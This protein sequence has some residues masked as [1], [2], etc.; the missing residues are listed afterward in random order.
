MSN[1]AYSISAL[2]GG[3]VVMW[4]QTNWNMKNNLVLYRILSGSAL[5]VIAVVSMTIDHIAYYILDQQMGLGNTWYYEVMRCVG[6]LA[7]P[8]FAFLIIEG[9]HHTRHVG[10]YMLAL[11]VTAIVAEIP[12]QLLGN[13]GSHNVVF[14]LLLG[15]VTIFLVDHIH[16]AP[17]LMLMETALFSAIATMLNTDYTWHGICLMAVFYLFRKHR[18]LTLLFGLPL[19]MEYG[20]IGSIIGLTIPLMYSDRRGFVQGQWMKY[21]FYIYYPLHMI[22]LWLCL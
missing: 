22:V 3:A 13:E 6:R 11:L 8:I 20:I 1:L 15:L 10:K 12:W 4:C 14:T 19:L 18:G 2:V 16:D 17:W 5:K 9:Y 7:F 21:I